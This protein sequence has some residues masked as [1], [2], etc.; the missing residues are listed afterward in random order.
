MENNTIQNPKACEE[1]EAD[2]SKNSSCIVALKTAILIEGG[3]CDHY[4]NDCTFQEILKRKIAVVEKESVLM[5]TVIL[6][7]L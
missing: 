3:F 6:L 2:I 5:L 1:M 4:V 7:W